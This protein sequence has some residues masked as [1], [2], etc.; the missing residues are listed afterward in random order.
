MTDAPTPKPDR[1]KIG[2]KVCRLVEAN[3]LPHF[4]LGARICS[5]RSFKNQGGLTINH[6]RYYYED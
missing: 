2:G 3:L 1:G 5:R 4:R 6:T